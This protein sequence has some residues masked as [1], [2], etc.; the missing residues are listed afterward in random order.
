VVVSLRGLL[1]RPLR[2]RER[3]DSGSSNADISG[4]LLCVP[5]LGEKSFAINMGAALHDKSAPCEVQKEIECLSSSS[6]MIPFPHLSLCAR[7][8][9]E[10][11]RTLLRALQVTDVVYSELS[12]TE[13]RLPVHAVR[14]YKVYSDSH[15]S[16]HEA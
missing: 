3:S 8:H 11:R 7:A 2:G 5:T 16:A 1:G 15:S 10:C 4:P 9:L 6:S 14:E 12:Q 13:H